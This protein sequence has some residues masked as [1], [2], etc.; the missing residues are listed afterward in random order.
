MFP[1]IAQGIHLTK[2]IYEEDCDILVTLSSIYDF[3]YPFS[4]FVIQRS[5]YIDSTSHI[6]D[7]KSAAY[8]TACDLVSNT[9][10]WKENSLL[11]LI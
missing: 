8:V 10:G 4:R 11:V 3:T 7:G 6:L 2:V 5:G 1:K 9:R